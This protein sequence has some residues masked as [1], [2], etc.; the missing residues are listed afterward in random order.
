MMNL[1]LISMLGPFWGKQ[2]IAALD[3]PHSEAGLTFGY[4][5]EFVTLQRGGPED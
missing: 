4:W 1:S 3:A 5:A 2:L